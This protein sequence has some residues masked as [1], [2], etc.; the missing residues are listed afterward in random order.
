MEL[1]NIISGAERLFKSLFD[2]STSKIAVVAITSIALV[3]LRKYFQER[4]KIPI[5]KLKYDAE[6]E[7]AKSK[8]ESN[9]QIEKLKC[10]NDYRIAK[11]NC[12]K[13]RAINRDNNKHYLKISE[14]NQ[15]KEEKTTPM[16]K[17]S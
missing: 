9:Y 2:S 4:L 12:D 6:R 16:T 13:E 3:Q 14:M 1:F 15:H 17:V 8:H 11:L 7:I 5:A 10:D